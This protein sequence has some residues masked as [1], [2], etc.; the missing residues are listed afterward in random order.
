MSQIQS[1]KS[2]TCLHDVAALLKFTAKGLAYILYGKPLQTKYH[3]FEILKRRGGSRQINAPTP[4][5][6]LLTAATL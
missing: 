5:L 2:A 3:S 6:M 4:D 1:L